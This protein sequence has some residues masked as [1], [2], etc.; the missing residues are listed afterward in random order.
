MGVSTILKRGEED[1]FFSE[2]FKAFKAKFEYRAD[3]LKFKVVAVTSAIAG[4]G[5]TLSCANLAMNLAS[6]GRKKVLL[7]DVDLR[8]ADLARGLNIPSMPGLSEFLSGTVG[9]KDILRN[10]YIPGLYV[11][12]AGTRVASPADLLAGDKFRSF[13]T[14]IRDHFDLIIMDTPPILPVA[15]TLSLKDQVDGFI[16]LYRTGFTPYNMLK[17]AI[18]EIGEKNVIGV[19]LN[20]VEP[21]KEK[22]YQRYYG[23]YYRKAGSEDPPV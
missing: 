18:E 17:Q 12:A 3:M 15:D 21:Q 9:L 22:Y 19:V 8:K 6:S 23:K 14:D 13:L 4:E 11:I 7:I 16:F 5:K 1:H 2:Q 20:G 10:S